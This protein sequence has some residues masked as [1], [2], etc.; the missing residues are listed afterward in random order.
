MMMVMVVMMMMKMLFLL[1]CISGRLFISSS[2]YIM[3]ALCTIHY[4]ARLVIAC[5]YRPL[6][7]L[8]QAL[9]ILQ[10]SSPFVVFHEFLE[11][12]VD[13]YLYLQAHSLALRMVLSDTWHR[14]THCACSRDPCIYIYV[15]IYV[16]MYNSSIHYVCTILEVV[17]TGWPPP[18]L[19]R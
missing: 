19:Y 14:Y 3:D 5:K 17:F 12:L 9:F 18:Q 7:I 15:C 16:C 6:P 10:P 4:D 8:K 2:S 1:L 11:P 13:C